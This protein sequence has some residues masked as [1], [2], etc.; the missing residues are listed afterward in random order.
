MIVIVDV[1]ISAGD[2]TVPNTGSAG[3]TPV[4]QADDSLVEVDIPARIG[5][6]VSCGISAMRTG[7]DSIDVAVM[8]G[9]TQVRYLSTLGSAA[10]GDG[11]VSWYA[12]GGGPFFLHS[13][14][15]GFIVTADD[16]DGSDV[17]FALVSNGNGTS[18]IE[19]DTNNTY[20]MKAMNYGSAP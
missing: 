3:F 15:R 6:R 7:A 4:L 13:T 11:D 18:I 8:V 1:L 19:G 5:D 9:D 2:I 14:D 16:L 20:Y 17:R 12:G 10:A